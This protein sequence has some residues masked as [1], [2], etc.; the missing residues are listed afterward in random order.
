MSRR[1]RFQQHSGQ[2]GQ[3]VA[4]RLGRAG[5]H[6]PGAGAAGTAPPGPAAGG[7]AGARHQAEAPRSSAAEQLPPA[8]QR[9]AKAFSSPCGK[10]SEFQF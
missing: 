9:G 7:A 3:V 5:K 10:I 1:N 4:E 2:V 8:Q 6:P